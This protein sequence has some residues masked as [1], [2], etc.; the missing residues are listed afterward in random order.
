ME[1][2]LVLV[3][4]DEVDVANE[5]GA[6]V[7]EGGFE[8]E[9]VHSG[10]EALNKLKEKN[11]A[12]VLLDIRMPKMLGTEV[13]KK[14]RELRKEGLIKQP[15]EIIM[16]TALDDAKNAWEAS[17]YY[18]FDYITKPFKNEDLLFRIK[19]AVKRAEANK[20]DDKIFK[21]IATMQKMIMKYEWAYDKVDDLWHESK[22]YSKGRMDRRMTLEEVP[23]WFNE[24]KLKEIFGDKFNPDWID[25]G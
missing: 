16:L 2:L 5:I 13:L 7:N 19:L 14:I 17:K 3:V 4:D 20:E 6:V 10:E 8:V 9:V 25:Q 18:A 15:I 23:K 12:V 11:F 24:D 21:T 22:G 1:K